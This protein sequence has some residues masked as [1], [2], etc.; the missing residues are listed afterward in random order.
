M[1]KITTK[2]FQE[3]NQENLENDEYV[4]IVQRV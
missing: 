4:P 1:D 2:W 3:K